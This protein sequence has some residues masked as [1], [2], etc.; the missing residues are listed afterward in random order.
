MMCVKKGEIPGEH[1]LNRAIIINV[2]RCFNSWATSYSDVIKTVKLLTVISP[3]DG[4]RECHGLSITYHC[5]LPD[6]L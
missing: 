4:L 5:K 3:T 2:E 1:E 6:F